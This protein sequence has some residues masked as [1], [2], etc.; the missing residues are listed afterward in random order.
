MKPTVALASLLAIGAGA[1][2]TTEEQECTKVG[3]PCWKL[4]RA[5]KAFVQAATPGPDGLRNITDTDQAALIQLGQV[6]SQSTSNPQT[7]LQKL[8]L[9]SGDKQMAEKR[10]ALPSQ[11]KCWDR[12]GFFCWKARRA[13][14]QAQVEQEKQIETRSPRSCWDR[15]GFFC[16]MVKRDGE[17]VEQAKPEQRLLRR[18]T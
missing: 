2:P 1:V 9:D 5:I 3:N 17:H 10:E 7:F 18:E 14:E 4:E 11:R 16:W 15:M 13:M 8:G 6:I 12:A